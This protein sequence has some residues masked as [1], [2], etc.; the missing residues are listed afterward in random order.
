MPFIIRVALVLSIPDA[1]AVVENCYLDSSFG[2][3]HTAL[4]VILGIIDLDLLQ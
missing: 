1:L 2:Q 3:C 4:S